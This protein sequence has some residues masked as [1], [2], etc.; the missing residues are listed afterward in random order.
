MFLPRVNAL[1]CFSIKTESVRHIQ[2]EL[3]LKFLQQKEESFSGQEVKRHNMISMYLGFVSVDL[4][5]GF[6]I[7]M[8]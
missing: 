4:I 2:E 8:H 7:H 5:N 1:L 6:M 3:A